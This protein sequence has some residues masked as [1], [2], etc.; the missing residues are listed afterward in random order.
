[1][2]YNPMSEEFQNECKRL[3]LT[4]YQYYRK[5]VEEGKLINPTDIFY[6]ERKSVIENAKCKDLKEYR[7]KCAQNKGC[8][9]HKE[10]LRYKSWNDGSNS[11][12]SENTDCS[13]WF[14]ELLESFL[15]QTFTNSTREDYHKAG[16]D[17]IINGEKIDSKARCL[18][19]QDS[20]WIGWSFQINFNNIADSFIL[21]GFEDNRLI[22][23]YVWKFG[24]HDI[25]RRKE[26]WNRHSFDITNKGEYLSRLKKYEDKYLLENLENYCSKIDVI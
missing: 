3:N 25:V 11:P 8:I 24:A 19:F 16:Y 18:R 4:G 5:L 20:G 21:A 15:H 12:K 22:P 10:Y 17:L 26:F 1:M 9:D 7:D 23:L 14:G 6:R 2:S 13:A